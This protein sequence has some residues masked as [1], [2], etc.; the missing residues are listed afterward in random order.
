MAQQN[1]QFNHHQIFSNHQ[2]KYS[3]DILILHSLN[4][5]TGIPNWISHRYFTKKIYFFSTLAAR[6]APFIC[7]NVCLA[8]NGLY[9]FVLISVE[10]MFLKRGLIENQE[11]LKNISRCLRRLVQRSQC[12]TFAS[13]KDIVKRWSL[14]FSLS[15]I[16]STHFLW[17]SSLP[18]YD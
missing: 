6:P 13:A 15:L 2:N 18:C 10:Q 16:S 14:S 7:I 8:L 1:H 9:V 4:I 11:I 3:V 5:F 17:L 12:K